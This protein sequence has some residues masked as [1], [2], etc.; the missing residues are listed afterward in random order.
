MRVFKGVAGNTNQPGK[1]RGE[2]PHARSP[3]RHIHG[4]WIDHAVKCVPANRHT[5]RIVGEQNRVAAQL[6]KLVARDD[7]AHVA[8]I[9]SRR[10]VCGR[11]LDDVVGNGSKRSGRAVPVTGDKYRVV[12]GC[13][14]IGQVVVIDRQLDRRI[15]EVECP[16]AGA[17]REDVLSDRDIE[18]RVIRIQHVGAVEFEALDGHRTARRRRNSQDGTRRPGNN[19]FRNARSAVRT[20]RGIRS[21]QN[22]GLVQIDR[23]CLRIGAGVNDHRAAGGHTVDAFLNRRERIKAHR[24]RRPAY[25]VRINTRPYRAPIV[26]NIHNGWRRRRR[27]SWRAATAKD[28]TQTGR[29]AE[30]AAGRTTAHHQAA[31][32]NTNQ[33]QCEAECDE[34]GA[35]GL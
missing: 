26:V 33:H 6:R 7:A 29:P 5:A 19:R 20:D 34:S 22:Y 18:G 3:G 14:G 24:R 23:A 35:T 9:H 31:C 2:R 1:C 28:T 10:A 4:I 27:R 30:P 15:Q 13:D 21:L 17:V 25:A 8:Q 32:G 12:I 11:V 16:V